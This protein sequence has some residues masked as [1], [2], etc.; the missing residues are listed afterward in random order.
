[1]EITK[2]VHLKER[3]NEV[4]IPTPLGVQAPGPR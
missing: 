4:N 3:L 1:M 2:H